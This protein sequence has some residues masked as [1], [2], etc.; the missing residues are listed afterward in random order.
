MLSVNS[1]AFGVTALTL[2]ACLSLQPGGTEATDNL[3]G[4]HACSPGSSLHG[5]DDPAEPEPTD[6]SA[7]FPWDQ[8]QP[9]V[10]DGF[11]ASDPLFAFGGQPGRG[12][13]ALDEPC[14][15]P[16]SEQISW[17]KPQSPL[18]VLA[19]H[20]QARAY[21]LAIL[22]FHEIVN[23]LMGGEPVVITYC[24][25]CNSALAFER[26]IDGRVLDFAVSGRLHQSNLVMY[27]RQTKSLWL[28]FTGKA[29]A[30][31]AFVG[32]TL[33]RI[34]TWL[35][36]WSEFLESYPD[37][38][39][40][41]RETGHDRDYDLNP[42]AGY[43]DSPAPDGHDPFF[44][45]RPDDSTG[46]SPK[47]RVVGLWSETGEAVALPL[48]ALREAR[49]ATVEL[50]GREILALWV[51]GKAD[52]LD[53]ARM[54]DGRDIGQ[55]GTYVPQ[56][57]IEGSPVNLTITPDPDNARRFVDEETGS[58]WTVLGHAVAGPLRGTRLQPVARDE[59]LWSVWFSFHPTTRLHTPLLTS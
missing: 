2:A 50:D 18:L 23:D 8:E 53:T 41:T 59:T 11:S 3:P 36:S 6:S 34:P 42:Y 4:D 31:E 26:S 33:E 25:L 45:K 16:A 44:G 7:Q 54:D 27:D 24:P 14:L 56:V 19:H 28:Q 49:Q 10:A 30:G 37:G 22:H 38:W 13:P 52:A 9:L 20:D 48:E 40:L 17:L 46:F 5:P 39:V 57:D 35:I 51:P 47:T 29:I 55:V 15:E 1:V 32:H 12:I 43:T 21:P 58:T